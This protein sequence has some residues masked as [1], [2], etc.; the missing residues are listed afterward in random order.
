MGIQSTGNINIT[1]IPCEPQTMIF[2]TIVNQGV[3][4]Q[5]SKLRPLRSPRR[6]KIRV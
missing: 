2:Q 4:K 3:M 6:L 1:F 5:G